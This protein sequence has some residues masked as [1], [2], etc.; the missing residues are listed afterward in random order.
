MSRMPLAHEGQSQRTL[1][2]PP[3]DGKGVNTGLVPRYSTARRVG[4]RNANAYRK[5]LSSWPSEV[6]PSPES[7]GVT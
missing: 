4:S 6:N 2:S 5:A 1:C 7:A 3:Q